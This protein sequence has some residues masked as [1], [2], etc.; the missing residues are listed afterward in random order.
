MPPRYLD[1]AR[2]HLAYR[3]YTRHPEA[4]PSRRPRLVVALAL[5]LLLV[6]GG[7]L[8]AQAG[9]PINRVVVVG[10]ARHVLDSLETDARASRLEN[11][12]CLTS[13]T[14]DDSVLTLRVL[15]PATYAYADSLTI[16]GDRPICG[17]G[18]PSLHTHVATDALMDPSST[19]LETNAD[20]GVWGLLLLL[21]PDSR[22]FVLVYP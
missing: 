1:Y 20:R 18:V 11:A 4:R 10:Q 21:Y 19:D 8:C 16:Y 22:R 15:S 13:Y 7:V 3:R 5:T 2:Y 14:V 6:V 17:P 12:G 9:P